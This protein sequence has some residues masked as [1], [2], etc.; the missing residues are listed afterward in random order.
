MILISTRLVRNPSSNSPPPHQ[1][2]PPVLM[3]MRS[4]QS[5]H[6][7]QDLLQILY[8]GALTRLVLQRRMTTHLSMISQEIFQ[9]NWN[10]TR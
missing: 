4:R 6:Q 10:S 1:T 2:P 3:V 5:P 7:P 9:L 8:K